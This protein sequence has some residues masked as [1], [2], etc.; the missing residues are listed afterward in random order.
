MP[1]GER[2][3]AGSEVEE[4]LVDMI[5]SMTIIRPKFAIALATMRWRVERT[6]IR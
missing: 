1:D 5:I 2:L 4:K 6:V 3:A